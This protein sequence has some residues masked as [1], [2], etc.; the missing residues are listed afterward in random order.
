MQACSLLLGRPWEFDT[1]AIHHGRS[2]KYALMYKGKK[3]VLLPLTPN[4]IAQCDRVIAETAKREL[5]NQ[6]ASSLKFDKTAP[7][8]SSTTIKLKSHV[9]LATKSDLVVP[10]AIDAPFHALVCR[11]F[12]F[13]LEDITTPLP[14]II[15]NLLQEFKDIFP[16]EIPLGLP[17]LRGIEHQIDLISGATLPNYAAYRTNLEETKKIQR[18]VQTLLDY[19]Y[20][21]ESLNPYTVLVILVPKKNSTWRMCVDCRAINNITIQYHFPIPRLNNILDELSGSIIFTKI[22][23]RSGYHHIKM[24]LDDKWKTTC[25]TKFGLYEWLVMPFGLTNTPSTFMKLMNVV[26]RSFIGKFM[27]VYFDNILIYSK[28]LNE[29]IKHLCAVFGTL[30]EANPFANLEKCTFCTDRVAFLS[31]VS[32]VVTPQGIEMDEAIFQ[33]IKSW[34]ILATL[35]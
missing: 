1:N 14:H 20:I 11:L 5:E 29:H 32:Y 31:Y 25:K 3:I 24:K 22:D 18:Q 19:G 30:Q 6:H 12:L 17:P 27:V 9:M 26:L 10:T 33:V 7:P 28:S 34:L 2:N 23:L 15:I 8:L 21:R 35:T 4:E 13:L 16:T